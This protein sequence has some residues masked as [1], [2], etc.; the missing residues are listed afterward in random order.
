MEEK[1]ICLECG[2][3]FGEPK[4]YRED[5]TPNGA[6]E[7]GSFI[8]EYYAC[9]YC[10]GAYRQAVRCDA[11]GEYVNEEEIEIIDKDY[12]CGKCYEKLEDLC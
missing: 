1:Y 11:C 9:P 8:N 7:G 6:F 4:T 3:I 2:E 12:I 10:E 5:C